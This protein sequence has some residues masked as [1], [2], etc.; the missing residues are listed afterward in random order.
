MP[1]APLSRPA[2][3]P[4]LSRPAV[5]VCG[6]STRETVDAAVAGGAAFVGLV[7]FPPS[8]RAVTPDEAAALAAPLPDDVRSVA[9]MVDP[10]DG[11]VETVARV[12]APDLIQLHGQ[13]TPAR[14]AAIRAKTGTPVM[15]AIHVTEAADL[16]A[17]AGY[18]DVA[19]WLIFDARPPKG[20]TLPGGN[21]R[22]FDWTLL[23]GRV[24]TL[25]WMLSGGLTAETLAEAVR[26]TG[27]ATVDVSSGVESTP[28]VKDVRRIR[29][30]LNAA[31]ALGD[32]PDVLRVEL[33]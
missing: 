3:S 24:T 2:T 22:P 31:R 7:F 32:A 16:E 21:G 26:V 8:P 4:V 28:G 12:L 1:V 14:V 17:T 33:G 5:K 23:A 20:A 27:A 19:D 6:L 29:A 15:K 13:E 11:L 18:E 10:D 30:F 9:L 25:P